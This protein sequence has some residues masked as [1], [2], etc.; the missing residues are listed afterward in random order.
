[1]R[2]EAL[3]LAGA[4]AVSQERHHDARGWFARTVCRDEFAA[5]GLIG[6]F[7]QCSTSFSSRRGIL[8]GMH[9]QRP[10]HAETKLVRC[11]RGAVFDVLLD[12]RP[13]SATFRCSH[14][15]ELSEH[16]GLAVYVPAGFAHGFQSIVDES[17]VFYQ[18]TEPYTPESSIGVRWDDPA[19]DIEW[20]IRPPILSERDATYADFCLMFRELH[21]HV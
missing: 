2:F 20:P 4:F 9:F 18:I 17:E 15:V 1:M 3:P 12:L 13:R 7:A 21:P 11:T 16:N 10:P 6:D 5:H 14:A 8:R 19:F